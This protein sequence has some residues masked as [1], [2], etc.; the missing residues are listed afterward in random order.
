M[1]RHRQTEETRK[2]E[3][4]GGERKRERRTSERNYKELDELNASEEVLAAAA[5]TT[6]RAEVSVLQKHI[7]FVKNGLVSNLSE[8]LNTGNILDSGEP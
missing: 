7:H 4:E 3:S 1:H 2:R 5:T 8:P 6:Q